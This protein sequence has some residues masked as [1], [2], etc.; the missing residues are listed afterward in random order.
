[1]ALQQTWIEATRSVPCAGLMIVKVR[2]DFKNFFDIILYQRQNAARFGP[3]VQ[4]AEI[5]HDL[6]VS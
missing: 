2:Y 6:T 4:A 3:P 5:F 1:M